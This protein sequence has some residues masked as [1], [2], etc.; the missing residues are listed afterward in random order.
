MTEGQ[1][2]EFFL[3][4]GQRVIETKTCFWY[5][6]RP[7]LYMSLPYYRAV[8]PSQ[9]EL[10]RVLLGGPA[11]ALRFPTNPDTDNRKVGIFLCSDRNYGFSS[12]QQ[13]MRNYTRR[14]LE[15][16]TVEAVEFG[17][18]AQHG[19]QLNLESFERQDR[20]ATTMT[21][22]Q[23]HR[24]CEVAAATPGFE[25]WGA[26]ARGRLAAFV[27]AALV[28]DCCHMHH[29]SAATEHL[30]LFP[31]HAL[32]FSVTR[33]VLARPEVNSVCYGADSLVT[34]GIDTY[35]SRMGFE[36]L[37]FGE[38]IVH[39][40]LLQAGLALGG[41]KVIYWMA[42]KYPQKEMIQRAAL[43]LQQDSTQAGKTPTGGSAQNGVP[44]IT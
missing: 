6:H 27:V 23:W 4:Q 35:K 34:P 31:N 10:A 18:L 40:P 32:N 16:C 12:L 38:R 15:N 20:D 39:N 5:S 21:E 9:G 2:A 29:Q 24:Y 33:L 26:W 36:R 11:A 8:S 41:R 44:G 22:S 37:L 1:F 19:H 30:P 17:Y 42:R 3:R 13:R 43:L 14:G 25:A 7:L 28:E